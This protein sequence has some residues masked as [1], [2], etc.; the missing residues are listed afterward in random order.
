MKSAEFLSEL[1]RVAGRRQVLTGDRATR[2]YTSGFRFGAGRVAAVVRPAGLVEMW[3]VLQL[4]VKAD[5]IVILQA[6]NTGLTGGSTPW[7]EDYDR[8]VVIISPMAID[9]VHPIDE[10]RQVVCLPGSTL[11]Q[12]EARLRPLEREPHSVI[13]SSCIGA[14]VVGGV[15]NNSGGALVRRGPAYTELALFARLDASGDLALVNNLGIDLPGDAEDMLRAV[16]RGAFDPRQIR[17]DAGRASA[18]HYPARVRDVDADR[19]ARFNADPECH[20]DASG[21]AGK[22][23]VFAVRLDTFPLEDAACTFYIGSNDPGELEGLRRR[24]LSDFVELPVSGEYIHRTAFDIAARYGKDSYLAIRH[25]G[26]ARL[27]QLYRVKGWIDRAITACGGRGAGGSDLMLQWLASRLPEHL[28]ARLRQYRDAYEHHLILKMSGGGIAEARALLAA[29]FPSQ[30]GNV[31]ECSSEEAEAAF[32]HRFAVAGAAVRYRLVHRREVQDIV[33]LDVALR[34]S[35]RDWV[36]RLP[37]AVAGQVS[38]ALYYG[39]FFCHVFHQ[40]YVIRSGGDPAAIEHAL[41]DALDARGAE[42][43][44]EHNVGHLYPAKPAL[45]A[46][47][48]RLDPR[49]M[50][51]PGI[52]QT[53]RR[54]GWE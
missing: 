54:A 15:C 50:F 17:A 25:L 23:V 43:P 41:L 27:P 33:S 32:L 34:P 35:E 2:P 51:N 31:F 28:P 21:S 8:E 12:L 3:R 10:G 49:N 53:S 52:G 13:G 16:E 29:T 44:A 36:E 22:V 30:S 47:Y 37:D 7:G 9:A 20:F 48:R 24:I 11:H 46:F 1:T 26:T 40:D 42:Y 18:S 45:A 19:P 39:H 4:C 14:S 5:R 38:H 6:A